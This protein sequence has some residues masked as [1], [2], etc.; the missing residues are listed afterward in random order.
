MSRSALEGMLLHISFKQIDPSNFEDPIIS[1]SQ[2][3]QTKSAFS[4]TN[5]ITLDVAPNEFMAYDN[6][7]GIL[8]SEPEPYN[9]F[10]IENKEFTLE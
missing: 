3:F 1:T 8:S 6:K 10:S 4:N 2:F 5:I 9:F 7:I